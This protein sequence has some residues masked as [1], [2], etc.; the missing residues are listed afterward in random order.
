MSITLDG[1][2]VPVY[3]PTVESWTPTRAVIV[4][5]GGARFVFRVDLT[6]GTIT[7]AGETFYIEN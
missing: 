4:A 5:N 1:H 6:A 2:D 3:T 7:H